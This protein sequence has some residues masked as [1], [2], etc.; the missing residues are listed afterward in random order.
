MEK[1]NKNIFHRTLK[2][3]KSHLTNGYNHMKHVAGTIDHGFN[4][5]KQAYSIVEPIIRQA[6]GNNHIHNNI[7]KTIGNYESMRN[8]VIESNNQIVN[9]G[10]RLGN[11]I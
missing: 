9:V 3:V 10:Q 4:I 8:Q 7:M 5:A 11:L 6:T 2:N 1:F